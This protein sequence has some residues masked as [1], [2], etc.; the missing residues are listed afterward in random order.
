MAL[1][2]DGWFDQSRSPVWAK[3]GNRCSGDNLFA[4]LALLL[5]VDN[6][7]PLPVVALTE[8]IYPLD[9]LTEYR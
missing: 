6:Q 9:C 1:G 3:H 2:L 7:K 5:F 8:L 4:E